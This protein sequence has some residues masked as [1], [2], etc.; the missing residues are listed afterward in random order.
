MHRVE[1]CTNFGAARFICQNKV[2]ETG[3]TSLDFSRHLRN[4]GK[5]SFSKFEL[6]RSN[7]KVFDSYKISGIYYIFI[8]YV[9]S[10][11]LRK[12]MHVDI[13]KNHCSSICGSKLNFRSYWL[14]I[15]V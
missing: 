1:L 15:F 13:K 3:L 6:K 8:L 5:T 7:P 2:R 14:K 10:T 12:Y 11:E 9:S 4:A